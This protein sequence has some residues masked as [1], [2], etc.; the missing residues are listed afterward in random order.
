MG[1]RRMRIG[2]GCAGG[3]WGAQDE[4]EHVGGLNRFPGKGRWASC[5]SHGLGGVHTCLLAM[6]RTQQD[7][8]AW[9]DKLGTCDEVCA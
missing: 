1:V 7:S 5:A 3:Q 4:D 6:T 9:Q 8:P 2:W